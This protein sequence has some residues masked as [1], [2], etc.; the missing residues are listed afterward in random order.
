MKRA[1]KLKWQILL[2][3]NFQLKPTKNLLS[4]PRDFVAIL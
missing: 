1:D 4:T 3:F 2:L